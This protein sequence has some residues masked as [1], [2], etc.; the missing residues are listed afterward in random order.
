MAMPAGLLDVSRET[1]AKLEQF[2]DLLGKWN[3]RINLVAPST[4]PDLWSRHILDSAQIFHHAPDDARHWVDLGS[5]GGLPGVVCAILAYEARPECRFT[6]IESDKRKSAFLMT[7][8]REL[9]VS[10]KVLTERVEQAPPQAADVVSARALAP[11][12]ALLALVARHLAENG[13]ALLPKGKNHSAE[14]AAARRG[15]HF[16][17]VAI[18]SQTDPL[19]RVLI[20]K[21][22]MRV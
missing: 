11:L 5:G 13:T 21:E 22:I 19:A 1:L 18:E 6:L 4:L 16:D 20:L 8:I 2:A 12:P 14:L 17:H 10:A 15:W 3:A 9:G 7:A